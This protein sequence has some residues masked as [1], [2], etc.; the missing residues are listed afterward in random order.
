MSDKTITLAYFSP[1][2]EGRDYTDGFISS[3]YD[4]SI[5]YFETV[6]E[7]ALYIST[8]NAKIYDTGTL[9]RPSH[10]YLNTPECSYT[11]LIDGIDQ[12]NAESYDIEQMFDEF[13]QVYKQN[14]TTL[15]EGYKQAKA[16]K[17]EYAKQKRKETS[18]AQRRAEYELLRKEFD[19]Q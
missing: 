16:E 10:Y 8:E 4:I 2:A 3:D 14:Y 17:E 7:A 1:S 5:E 13:N 9:N 11:L 19:K 18:E 6:K 12:D 15:V